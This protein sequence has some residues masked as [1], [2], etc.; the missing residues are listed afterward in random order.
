M[1]EVLNYIWQKYS[2]VLKQTKLVSRY[3]KVPLS[4]VRLKSASSGDVKTSIFMLLW[5]QVLTTVYHINI[6]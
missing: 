2:D 6:Y 1:G 5:S 3:F 4:H